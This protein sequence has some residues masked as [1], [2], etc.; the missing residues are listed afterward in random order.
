MVVCF[1]CVTSFEFHYF[2]GESLNINII[3]IKVTPELPPGLPLNIN[4]LRMTPCLF[5]I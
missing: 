3:S 5:T 4:C 2:I 1:D